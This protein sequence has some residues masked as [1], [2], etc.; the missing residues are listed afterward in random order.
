MSDNTDNQPHAGDSQFD[1]VTT[2]TVAQP[3]LK[4][5]SR[6]GDYVV[7]GLLGAGG[8]GEVYRARDLRL[9]RSVAIKVIRS[10]RA[11]D[12]ASLRRFEREARA[13]A[14]LNHPNII[15]IYHFGEHDGAPYLV[16]ELLDGETL[17][18]RLSHGKLAPHAAIDIAIQMTGGLFAAYDAGIVHRDLKPENVFITKNGTVKILDFGLAKFARHNA[19]P[20]KVAIE[21]TQPGLLLGTLSY[22][23]P[24]Q[25]RGETADH[26]SDI[27]TLGTIL[28]EMLAGK[29]P[30]QKLTASE[31]MA[32][33]LHETEPPLAQLVPAIPPGLQRIV[34]RCLEKNPER[35]FQ[36]ASDLGFALDALSDGGSLVAPA[37]AASHKVGPRNRWAWFSAFLL[38]IAL[39][40]AIV[41]WHFPTAVPRVEAVA[42]L[43]NDGEPKEESRLATDGSRIFFNE[44]PPGGLRIAEV[45]V[46]GGRTAT[47]NSGLNNARL[48]GITADGSA[49]LA[50]V[51]GFIDPDIPLWFIPLPAGEPRR[52]ANLEVRDAALFPN[53]DLAFI[54]GIGLFTA[55]RDGSNQREIH[56]A[57]RGF[58]YAPAVSPDARHIS[59]TWLYSARGLS[60]T[61]EE[62]GTDGTNR[63]SV[64]TPGPNLSSVCCGQWSAD[65]KHL[66]FQNLNE[67]RWDLWTVATTKS[68]LGA[69]PL[70]VRLTA[71]PLSYEAPLPARDGKKVFAIGSQ[72]RG[73]LVR[74]DTTSGQFVP[75]LSGISATDPN[76]SRDGHWLT[77]VSYPDHTVWRSFAGGSKPQQL[78]FPPLVGLRPEISQDGTRVVFTTPTN[79]VYVVEV[80]G[81]PRKL[82]VTATS[83]S[84]SPDARSLLLTDFVESKDPVA[85][86]SPELLIYD[87]AAER[88]SRVQAS[89]GMLGGFWLAPDT[90]LAATLKGTRLRLFNLSTRQWTDFVTESCL[91]W[92]PSVDRKLIYVVTGT[93][94]PELQRYRI[95]D[96]R[97]E[98]I[99]GLNLR[100]VVD[101]YTE[102]QVNVAPDGSPIFTRDIG[103]EE[104]YALDVRWP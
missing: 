81:T 37:P 3:A 42:Q 98:T 64:V 29:R 82:N 74:Y 1:P 41:W 44:G 10:Y 95:S 56:Q 27:F 79:D 16:S 73:E 17:R 96:G 61:V 89:Q 100:R 48:A 76:F 60:Q 20:A 86:S 25:V 92:Y 59:F 87:L 6:L 91:N 33:I 8:M 101:P 67:G 43:T 28:Y 35:R 49:L 72:P 39:A 84:W 4:P 53:G 9:G 66:V 26:R 7:D 90:L 58:L 77:Y 23:S 38:G 75:Y 46:T 2:A 32:A 52:V 45:S 21:T 15:A 57:P 18:H 83:A 68:P 19:H 14:A 11:P 34:H 94:Q 54:K 31:T 50:G 62:V 102:T 63:R 24:E 30:F 47:F 70:P 5:G 104:V 40:V 36:S 55:N 51:G 78:S 65:G 71:G 103:T 97:K 85:P 69:S 80:G 12:R 88:A 93:E 13:T 22:M 99:T